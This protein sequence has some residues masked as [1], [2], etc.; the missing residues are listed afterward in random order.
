VLR[1]PLTFDEKEFLNP[2][3]LNATRIDFL[4][5]RPAPT[6][7]EY[8]VLFPDKEISIIPKFGRTNNGEMQRE[9]DQY[10]VEHPAIRIQLTSGARLALFLQKAEEAKK[11]CVKFEADV[12]AKYRALPSLRAPLPQ[13]GG[14]KA[15]VYWE[16]HRH[17]ETGQRKRRP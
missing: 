16:K 15:S 3:D 12:R 9:F 4:R 1:R 17:Q 14:R 11:E 10:I 13:G 2:E 6:L 7:D 5:G 8:I